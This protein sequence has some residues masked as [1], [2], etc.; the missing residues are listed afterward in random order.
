MFSKHHK[1]VAALLTSTFLY[2]WYSVLVK[3]LGFN[4]PIFY[5][6]WTRGLVSIPIIWLFFL[7]SKETWAPLKKK[8]WMWISIRAVVGW[9]LS[10]ALNY[11][12]LVYLPIGTAYFII[13]AG[14]TI[15]AYIISKML[16][17]E[18]ITKLRFVSLIM[19]LLGLLFVYWGS[20]TFTSPSWI[21]LAL[22]A[23]L[24]FAIWNTLSKKIPSSIG[25]TQVNFIDYIIGTVSIFIVSLLFKEQWVAPT[26]TSPWLYSMLLGIIFI[27]TGQLMVYGFR[28][29][30]TQIA[31]LIMLTEIIFALFLSAVLFHE[32]IPQLT[33]IGGICIV[34]AIVI[35][36]LYSNGKKKQV[37]LS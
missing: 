33:W 25:A 21:G 3:L 26:L 27:V 34:A 37:T 10:Y 20:I 11:W 22:L 13:Y 35:P 36:E 9:G 1:A 8:D 24:A 7:A 32:Q 6:A 28:N 14:S 23:G 5:A 29:I 2:G 19:A 4:L 17:G 16:F 31:S 18:P 30:N 15:S 12:A